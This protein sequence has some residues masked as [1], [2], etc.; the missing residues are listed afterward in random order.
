MRSESEQAECWSKNLESRNCLMRKECL[1]EEVS[2]SVKEE[3]TA[4]E[5]DEVNE[6]VV[7]ALSS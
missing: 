1:N 6:Q 7:S 4:A 3:A 2:Q 5:E